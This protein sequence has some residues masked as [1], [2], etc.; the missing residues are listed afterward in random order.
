MAIAFL[1]AQWKDLLMINYPCNPAILKRYVPKGTEIETFRGQAL[2][3]LVGFCFYD[4]RVLGVRWPGHVN[5]PEINLRFYVVRREK[6]TMKRGV[7]FIRE[8]VPKKLI[9]GIA[10]TIFRERYMAMP[11]AVKKENHG[12]LTVLSYSWKYKGQTHSMHSEYEPV[13]ADLVK[14]SEEEF[15][16]EH[17][18]GY[19]SAYEY[20]VAH[21]GW[22]LYKLISW[23]SQCDFSQYGNEFSFLN[24]AQ[25]SSVF[26]TEGSEAIVGMPKKIR[27]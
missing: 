27:L 22:K 15:L 18:W 14:D 4:T 21:P 23:S 3:S 24:H 7:V 25:P 9:A 17:Y 11:A 10:N 2:I 6:N 13:L 12:E 1:K 16:T 20:S 8:I 5:F 19:S 26:V